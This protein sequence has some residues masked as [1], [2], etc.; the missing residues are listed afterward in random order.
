MRTGGGCRRSRL[1]RCRS[2]NRRGRGRCSQSVRRKIGVD[3]VEGVDHTGQHGSASHRNSLISGTREKTQQ[4]ELF[5]KV[6]V[7]NSNMVTLSRNPRTRRACQHRTHQHRGKEV[8]TSSADG[9]LSA[10]ILIG[11]NLGV[12][13]RRCSTTDGIGF[14]GNDIG[15][16]FG[17]HCW[18]FERKMFGFES[19]KAVKINSYTNYRFQFLS[20]TLSQT[21]QG[22]ECRIFLCLLCSEEH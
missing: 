20:R 18:M 1:S 4:A 13:D 15:L 7:Q 3:L 6:I 21:I 22:M 12:A 11:S 8:A 9:A 16:G 17:R 14:L 5:R 19:F 2:G 10:R